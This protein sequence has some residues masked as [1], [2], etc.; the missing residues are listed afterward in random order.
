MMAFARLCILV[1]LLVHVAALLTSGL[2]AAASP[3]SQLSRVVNPWIH[4]TG[5]CALALAWVAIGGALWSREAGRLWK[6]GCALVLASAAALLYIAYYFA[7]A[8][9]AVLFGPDANDPLS[10]LA[11]LLG[12]AMG[13][14]QPG[15]KRASAGIARLNLVI[16]TIWIGLVPVIPFLN[17]EVLGAYERVV[18][19][20]MLLWTLMLTLL[21]PS[22]AKPGTTS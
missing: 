14:L 13:A 10:V 8:P 2:D 15:L 16:L 1:T 5:L 22:T 4:S 21:P 7:T 3:I 17:P 12:V 11:S 20:L 18:G 19:T 9:D 6:A